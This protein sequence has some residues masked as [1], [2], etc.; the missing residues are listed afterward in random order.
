ML[1]RPKRTA[2][3]ASD[4][5]AAAVGHGGLRRLGLGE[6]EEQQPCHFTRSRALAEKG[7]QVRHNAARPTPK[8]TAFCRRFLRVSA[9]SGAAS[10]PP[11]K[12]RGRGG[13][14]SAFSGGVAL[15][16]TGLRLPS[17]ALDG[18]ARMVRVTR[19][20]RPPAAAELYGKPAALQDNRFPPRAGK[21]PSLQ[22]SV[23]PPKLLPRVI[24]RDV[25]QC[26]RVQQKRPMKTAGEAGG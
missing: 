20:G 23:A 17:A 6:G 4:R 9:H 8:M 5:P 19:R 2:Y 14:I 7:L 21:H 10:N 22:Q 3:P 18:G 12:D 11:R 15:P 26:R 13:G 25:Q 24:S 16:G 1:P